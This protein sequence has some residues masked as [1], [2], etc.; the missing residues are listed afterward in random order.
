MIAG[1]LPRGVVAVEAYDDAVPVRLFPAEEELI[2]NAV[3]KRRTEFSTARRCAREALAMLGHPPA[4]ILSG[5]RGAPVWPAG[6]VG[7]ITHC[8][9]YRTAVVAPAADF[10]TIG[11]DAEPNEPLPEGVLAAIAL[12]GELDAVAR[13][14]A[15]E[16]GTHWDRLLF[17]AKEAVYKAWFPLTRRWLGFE[18]A[19][20]RV[21]PV[22]CRFEARLLVAA[23]PGGRPL[24]CFRG[25]FVTAGML[26]ATAIAVPAQC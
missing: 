20:V 26:M 22:T 10:W 4:P 23:S 25:R 7:S 13:L 16:P 11:V 6:V 8:A 15:T 1:I 2:R 19:V 17:C 18:E 9:G 21:D 12:P 5:E 24:P 14:R 3:E